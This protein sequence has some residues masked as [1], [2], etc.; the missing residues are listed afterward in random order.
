MTH[1]ECTTNPTDRQATPVWL[2]NHCDQ[3]LTDERPGRIGF[4]RNHIE[5]IL[6]GRASEDLHR[7]VC[8][9]GDCKPPRFRRAHVN[10]RWHWIR[11][12]SQLDRL[13]L[14]LFRSNARQ[15]VLRSDWAEFTAQAEQAGLQNEG[16]AA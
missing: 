16:V 6:A 10:F 8:Y 4:H 11:S 13:T 15:W 1:T 14:E 5:D 3:P 9:H 12:R 2:C 7:W